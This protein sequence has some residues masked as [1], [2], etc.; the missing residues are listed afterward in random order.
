MKW[1]V[2]RETYLTKLHGVN[3]AKRRP[4]LFGLLTELLSLL[5][6][7]T[8]EIVE[9]VERWRGA[10]RSDIPFIWGSSN[11]LVKVAGDTAFLSR[12]PGLEQ[13]LGVAIYENPFLCHVRLD[14]RPACLPPTTVNAV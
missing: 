6:R 7:I 3:N 9:A 10:G 2:L 4:K 1:V 13:H 14:G 5:R 11:Y 8:V 12:L